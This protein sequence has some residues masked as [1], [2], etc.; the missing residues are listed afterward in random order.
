MNVKLG[1]IGAGVLFFLGQ[2]VY[3][4][5]V[6]NDT[7]PD[8]EKVMK[9]VVILGYSRK[10]TKAKD[11]TASTTVTAEKFENRP[12]TSFLNSLQGES[13]GVAINA[14]SGSPGSGKID[15]IIRGINSLSSGSEPLYVIDGSIVNS[16][17]FRNLND[18]DIESAAILRDAGATA[19]YGNRGNNG[20]IV[21]T[22]KR[23]RFN[24]PLR[25][26]YSGLTGINLLPENKYNMMDSKQYLGLEKK[27]DMGF[28]STL[29]QE[30]IDNYPTNTNWRDVFYRPGFTQRHDLSLSAGGEKVNVYTSL[31]YLDVKGI[32][33]ISDFQRFTV[34]NNLSGKSATDRFT[35]EVNSSLSYSKRNQLD[36]ETNTAVRNNTIQNPLHGSYQGLPYLAPNKYPSGQAL[37]D[38]IGTN[39]NGGNS[40]YVLEDILKGTLPNR[41]NET[42]ILLNA[43]G[44]YK[45][46]EDLSVRN[47]SAVDYKYSERNFARAPWSY[48]AINVAK[49]SRTTTNPNPFGGFEFFSKNTEFNF[50]TITSVLYHKVIN[51]VH[52][53]DVSGNFDYIKIHYNNTSQQ[54]TGLNP[55]T[56]VFGAGTGY[57]DPVY[58]SG[59][60]SAASPTVF[61][62]PTASASAVKAGTLALFGTLDYDYDGLFGLSGVIRRDGSYRFSD[63]NKWG[64]F[65]SVAGRINLEKTSLVQNLNLDMFKLRASY[66]KTGNQNVIQGTTGTNPLLVAPNLVRETYIFANGYDN[67]SAQTGFGGLRNS[68]LQWEELYQANIGLDVRLLN[69]RLDARFDVYRKKTEK[70]YSDIYTSAATSTFG[71]SG[72]NGS[73]ENRGIEGNI[74]YEILRNQNAKLS[75]YA[76]ASYNEN[77]I[78]SL[79]KDDT[80]GNLRNVVGG[81]A[82]EWY[83]APYAGVNPENGNALFI[84]KNG[85][86]VEELKD[87]DIVATGKNYLPKWIGGFGINAE[88]KGFFLDAHFSFQQGA[89]KYDNSMDWV[90]DHTSLGDSNLSADLLNMWTPENKTGDIPSFNSTNVAYQGNSDRFLKDASFI[91][92]KNL[93]FGYNIPKNLLNDT[94]IR[95]MKIFV[96]GENLYTWTKWKGFDP[97]PNFSYSLSVYPNMRTFSIGANIDF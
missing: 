62:V 87:E 3:G 43:S 25:V 93:N 18:A 79:T 2:D 64:T 91:R 5:R 34:R 44:T 81:M 38:N 21:I 10:T 6:K 75:V 88:V 27:Y 37:Y 45:L 7:L 41:F 30:Q 9:D 54:R 58:F 55:K 68:L 90:Y 56:W 92:F 83:F 47:R 32:I 84:S 1:I 15:I 86:K 97:E 40:I 77:K 63:G 12:T 23:G 66:G 60:T 67:I 57:I 33:P 28:G 46:T 53:L 94:A 50:N 80:A 65:W 49:S 76:N 61:Y 35:Y 72:N 24:S 78:L 26:S 89:Y 36:E 14:S 74:R 20:V 11:V 96:A 29:T 82:Y 13:P 70:M 69:N 8:S 19:V 48:L 4:Q 42:G 95:G 59:A 39:F 16:V 85:T 71:I 22:T 51:D 31:G 73:I 17:Q 52:T